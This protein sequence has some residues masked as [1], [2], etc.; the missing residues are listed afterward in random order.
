[1][2]WGNTF[3]CVIPK[4]LSHYQEMNFP[5]WWLIATVLA[6]VTVLSLFR[7]I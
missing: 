1:M 7:V 3:K 4:Y 2:S 5:R 6:C